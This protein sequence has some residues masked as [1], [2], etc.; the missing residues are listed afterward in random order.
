MSSF[1]SLIVTFLAQLVLL[2]SISYTVAWTATTAVD[3][4]FQRNSNAARRRKGPSLFP[5]TL[6][7][8][9][10]QISNEYP[11]NP[12]AKPIPET[13]PKSQTD[14]HDHNPLLL[15]DEY[16]TSYL[17]R[18]G[19]SDQDVHDLI[20]SRHSPDLAK[21]QKVLTAHLMT[22][23]FENMDQ[24]EHPSHRDTPLI[25]RKR[26]EELPSLNV[27]KS[28]EKIIFQNRGGFCFE[29]NFAFR[30]L[31][32]SLG[33]N[34][35]LALA[36]VACNQPVPGHVVILV[37]NVLDADGPGKVS[38]PV[39]VD[40]GFGDPGVCDVLLPM[41]YNTPKEDTHGDLFEFRVDDDSDSDRFDTQLCRTRIGVGETGT[42]PK[43]VG[44]GENMM[45]R[46]RLNDD[47]EM[48]AVE[49]S[50]GLD[51]VLTT[52]PTFNGKRICVLSD[53]RGHVTLG[54]DY[55]KWVEKGESVK[56]IELP[57]ETHWRAA[58]K[59]HFEVTLTL[60]SEE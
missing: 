57:T 11:P 24:H 2:V 50:E 54:K 19:F 43:V 60:N 27:Y 38:V 12:I 41:Q 51:R 5:V 44:E 3:T 6:T 42:G 7:L 15:A 35:R 29:L 20:S 14:V 18:I 21:L 49:F 46:F 59:D 31:L 56:R 40:V 10:S 16:L 33:Y 23:P 22:V 55:I 30:L 26:P 4:T 9:M 37:D 28:L 17:K 36:D 34:T 1:R 13:E 58:L 25:P 45:Y 32:S 53:S 39:L 48:T 52:S 47:M 8:N